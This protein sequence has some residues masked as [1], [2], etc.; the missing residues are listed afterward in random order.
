MRRKM[1]TLISMPTALL[2]LAILAGCGRQESITSPPGM[3][4]HEAVLQGDLDA[5]QQ[6]IAA[7][8]D[9]NVRDPFGGASPLI[10]ASTLGQ[11]EIARAL[12]EGGADLNCRNNDGS[13]ALHSAAFLCHTDI[14]RLLLDKGADTRVRNKA[15]AT[16]YE[17]V[18]GPFEEVKGI[19]DFL[20]KALGPLGLQ[21]DYEQ[22]KATRPEIAGMLR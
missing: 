15:G 20:A 22:L 8:S 18:A 3:G 9:L 19:Y 10:T 1:R 7:C 5:V 4:L 11:T 14:V 13:T 16:A 2:T 21:L 17:S 6:H 12:I